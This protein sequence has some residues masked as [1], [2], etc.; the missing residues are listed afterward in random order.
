MI[1]LIVCLIILS[2]L[3]IGTVL[4]YQRITLDIFYE[5]VKHFHIHP[6]WGWH[7]KKYFPKQFLHGY[8]FMLVIAIYK[9][10][11]GITIK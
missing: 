4:G 1:F 3:M 6:T 11:K 9:L 2:I 7:L 8:K 10:R 5:P